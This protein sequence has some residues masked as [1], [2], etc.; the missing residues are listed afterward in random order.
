MAERHTIISEAR[1]EPLPTGR[2]GVR[3]YVPV[4]G[5]PSGRWSRDLSARLTTELAGQ[6]A[7][8]HLRLNDIVHGDHIVLEGVEESE[9][10]HLADALH[11]AVDATNDAC[12]DRGEQRN[13]NMPRGTADAIAQRV[14]VDAR[15]GVPPGS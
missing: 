8:G 13:E 6:P 9:A 4:S 14:G 11:R 2:V 7:V 5:N 12:C 3:L 1:G 15:P 10:S